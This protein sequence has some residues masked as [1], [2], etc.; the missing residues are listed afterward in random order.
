M[1]HISFSG[2]LGSAVSALAAHEAGFEFTLLF[3]DT[4]IEDEDLYRFVDDV[5]SAVGVPVTRLC[6]GRTPWQ[7]FEDK[8]YI[9]NTRTAHCSSELKTKPIKTWLDQNA[10]V[11]EPLVLGMDWSEQD[12]IDRAVARWSPRPV[13]SLLN[14]L[15]VWRPD[16]A[17]IL[18][19]FSIKPPRLYDLGFTHNNCGGFCVK[20]GKKQ[21]ALLKNVFPER[22]AFH[23]AEMD[24]VMQSIGSTARPF[25]RH[26]HNKTTQYLTLNEYEKVLVA[27]ADQQEDFDFAGCGCFT[28]D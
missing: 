12:R 7:V 24:R 25:L 27:G 6:D 5:S 4:K 8:R 11:D 1:Y 16:Y 10:A 14:E 20:A 28:D 19:R 26:T 3:A 23:A 2:G 18:A 15:N 22:Y 9:G 17:K 21:F 13:I